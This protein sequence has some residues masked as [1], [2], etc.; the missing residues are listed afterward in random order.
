[1]RRHLVNGMSALRIESTEFYA[2]TIGGHS[3]KTALSEPG[4][5]HSPDNGSAHTLFM[6]VQPPVV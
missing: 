6:D 3:K 4:G 2:A 1:M 5:R